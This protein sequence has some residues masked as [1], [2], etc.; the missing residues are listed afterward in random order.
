MYGRTLAWPAFQLLC[1]SAIYF[2]S[3]VSQCNVKFGVNCV[4]RFEQECTPLPPDIGRSLTSGPMQ[5]ILRS[6]QV[7]KPGRI[8]L[9]ANVVELAT[10]SNRVIAYANKSAHQWTAED[11]QW[12]DAHVGAN[13][14]SCCHSI[15]RRSLNSFGRITLLYRNTQRGPHTLVQWPAASKVINYRFVQALSL[16]TGHQQIISLAEN[17]RNLSID[18]NGIFFF[19]LHL[20]CLH[21]NQHHAFQ[22]ISHPLL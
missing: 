14:I 9:A 2:F 20:E 11:Y 6:T 10:T 16:Q 12:E 18:P 1:K 17:L 21:H 5:Q 19:L 4:H 22:S 15:N 13:M 3:F 8:L 7:G